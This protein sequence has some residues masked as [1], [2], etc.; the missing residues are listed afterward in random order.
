LNHQGRA[1]LPRRPNFRQDEQSDVLVCVSLI[2]FAGIAAFAGNEIGANRQVC[3][4]IVAE[5]SG[6][7]VAETLYRV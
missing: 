1:A 5:S 7:Y 6:I 2:D 4:T 3:P